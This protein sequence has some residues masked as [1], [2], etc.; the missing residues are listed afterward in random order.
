MGSGRQ[1]KFRKGGLRLAGRRRLYR[2]RRKMQRKRALPVQ[3]ILGCVIIATLCALGARFEPAHTATAGMFIDGTIWL[4]AQLFPGAV[5]KTPPEDARV[6]VVGLDQR[7][8]DAE[9][10]RDLPRVLHSRYLAEAARKALDHGATIAIFDMIFAFEGPDNDRKL[11]EAMAEYQRP[12][13]NLIRKERKDGKVILAETEDSK[14]ARR[15]SG[16]FATTKKG[17]A[18]A[19]IPIDADGVMRRVPASLR[20]GDGN[21]LVPTLSGLVRER[22]GQ[23]EPDGENSLPWDKLPQVQLAAPFSIFDLPS[24]PLADLAVCDDE[25]ALRSMFEGRAVFFGGAVTLEDQ[26]QTADRY[27][28]RRP[29]ADTPCDLQP[30]EGGQPGVFVHA[31][32]VDGALRG[33][34]PDVVQAGDIRAIVASFVIALFAA[35]SA[36]FLK[37]WNGALIAFVVLPIFFFGL[38]AFSLDLNLLFAFAAPILSAPVAFT[39][40]LCLKTLIFDQDKR[41]L[42][43]QFSKYLSNDVIDE[44]IASGAEPKL[45]GATSDITV[46]FVDLSGFTTF[47]E[48]WGPHWEGGIVEML[49]RYLTIIS[50]TIEDHGG[51]VD[52]FIGDAVMAIWNEPRPLPHHSAAAVTAA[53]EIRK[54][55]TEE[56]LKGKHKFTVKIG[57]ERGRA[58]V[59]NVGSPRR[60]EFSAIGDT[61]NLAARLEG[62]SGRFGAGLLVGPAAADAN[63]AS[64]GPALLRLVQLQV[65]GR[66]SATSVYTPLYAGEPEVAQTHKAALRL[67]EAG[68]FFAAASK[69]RELY[70]I[71]EG[72]CVPWAAALIELS[73]S[74]EKEPPNDWSGLVQLKDK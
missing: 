32:A 26:V 28:P 30:V 71:L 51:Y 31:A 57:L 45:G 48:E 58:T 13:I 65:K 42:K 6:I 56:S 47:S 36:I 50:Q 8:L 35:L 23:A 37:P 16:L 14:P 46:M 73:E 74:F 10:F 53:L 61:V 15:F 72:G 40:S 49:N 52:K 4:R 1:R 27:L 66:Q 69:W 25:V 33:W 44:M 59:G 19:E 54:K 68:D 29:M 22:L 39:L 55:V 70:H 21:V 17:V 24:V 60:L 63:L 43:R 38:R 18:F 41:R 12:L 34:A 3:H 5:E 67:F 20:A 64:G 9:G 62:A 11:S 2:I 7:T